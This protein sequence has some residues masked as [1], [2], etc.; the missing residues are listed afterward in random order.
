MKREEI[1]KEK[2][3]KEMSEI[4]EKMDKKR[5]EINVLNRKYQELRKELFRL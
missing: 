3:I 5:R 1:H 2:V 4:S